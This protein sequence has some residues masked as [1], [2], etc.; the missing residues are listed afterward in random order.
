MSKVNEIYDKYLES[1]GTSSEYEIYRQVKNTS[2]NDI[3]DDVDTL[4]M[5]NLG[6]PVLD[7]VELI[8]EGDVWVKNKA[9]RESAFASNAD[10]FRA[11]V[12]NTGKRFGN[13][14]MDNSINP[15]ALHLNNVE[16]TVDKTPNIVQTTIN[17]MNGTF[18]EF[19]SDGDY[20][21]T[22]TGQ[23]TGTSE[24]QDDVKNLN[25]LD[26]IYANTKN[27]KVLIRSRFINSL[28]INEVIITDYSLTLNKEYANVIDF[29]INLLSDR[30]LEIITEIK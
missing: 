1:I 25:N 24:I 14:M 13:Q 9:E 19:Y 4:K 11:F 28:Q 23:L 17:G 21:I 5:S 12:K 2:L 10:G 15:K 30:E 3:K 27:E 29:T 26:T 18:K 6:T 8:L 22:L 16:V 20:V 7:F